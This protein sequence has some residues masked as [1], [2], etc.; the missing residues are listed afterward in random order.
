MGAAAAEQGSPQFNGD[1]RTDFLSVDQLTPTDLDKIHH[2]AD[3]MRWLARNKGQQPTLQGHFYDLVFWNSGST[4]TKESFK[5][6]ILRLGAGFVDFHQETSSSKTKG[7]TFE[8]TIEMMDAY[9]VPGRDGLI[10]RHKERGSLAVAAEL[11]DTDVINAGDGTGEHPT[12]A[13][14]DTKTI[15][16]RFERLDE[17]HMAF[18]GDIARGRTIHST[19]PLLAAMGVKRMT[20]VA[21][22][23]EMRAEE[24]MLQ[25]LRAAGVEATETDEL[26]EAAPTAD[27]IYAVRTQYEFML[28]PGYWR[29]KLTG[30][31]LITAADMKDSK[32]LVMHPLPEDKED[33]NFDPEVRCDPR[34]IVKEQ[35]AWGEWTRMALLALQAG[36]SAM[37]TAELSG[38]RLNRPP[39]TS[40]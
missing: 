20:F 39:L 16:E 19:A 26:R 21:P 15:R 29:D 13:V 5:H 17:T 10:I 12:Q 30:K 11:A 28:D 33:P 36:K 14:L 9:L 8:D 32:A 37:R 24:E 23:E 4:R 35:A 3:A 1:F 34:C 2:E 27:M 40:V 25:N 6:A 22:H 38:M 31:A 7:E 18:F